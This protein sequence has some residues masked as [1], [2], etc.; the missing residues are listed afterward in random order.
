MRKPA[1]LFFAVSALF[2]FFFLCGCASGLN[3]PETAEPKAPDEPSGISDTGTVTLPDIM[4]EGEEPDATASPRETEAETDAETTEDATTEDATTEDETEKGRLYGLTIVLD[5]G[6]GKFSEIFQEPVAP[7]SQETKKAFSTGTAGSYMSEAELNLKLAKMLR[8][9]LEAE[10]AAVYLT[11][12]DEYSISNVARA[13]FANDLEADLMF[14]IHADGNEDTTVH[15]TAMLVPSGGYIGDGLEKTSREIGETILAAM[16]EKTG[17]KNR[18]I[19]PR[20]D[21]TGFNWSRVPVVLV[22]CG[23]MSNPEEDALLSSESYQ[24]LLVS[25]MFEG[26]LNYFS[27]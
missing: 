11:R 21:L 23:F 8:P 12:E 5:P 13:E 15:G 7:G 1:R 24:E 16:I 6:H 3:A 22:E 14:R 10:G 25:G 19:R 4:T 20:T 27:K 9:L 18:G 26:I 17:A 2:V